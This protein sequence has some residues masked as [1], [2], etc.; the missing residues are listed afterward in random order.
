MSDA[1]RGHYSEA[2]GSRIF[3]PLRWR[4]PAGRTLARPGP[5]GRFQPMPAA[6]ADP[7]P[8]GF[9][10]VF[11]GTC[12]GPPRR[13]SPK[14]SASASRSTTPRSRIGRRT[15]A[16]PVLLG[17]NSMS[18]PREPKDRKRAFSCRALKLLD[19]VPPWTGTHTHGNACGILPKLSGECVSPAAGEAI[20]KNRLARPPLSHAFS[21][22]PSLSLSLSLWERVPMITALTAPPWPTRPRCTAPLRSRSPAPP[23]RSCSVRLPTARRPPS[24]CSPPAG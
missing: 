9:R 5:H 16:L 8:P 17:E 15:C 12:P 22:G 1:S 10:P 13:L 4:P 24:R 7:P 18:P 14:T 19:L 2:F 11:Q 20:V 3:N 21:A 23:P 6:S